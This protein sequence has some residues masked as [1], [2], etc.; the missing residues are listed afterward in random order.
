MRYPG[1]VVWIA[2]LAGVGCK[3][4]ARPVARLSDAAG[5]VEESRQKAQQTWQATAVGHTFFVGDGVRTGA[6]A[7]ARI[8]LEPA[9]TLSLGENSRVR[10]GHEDRRIGLEVGAAEIESG[11]GGVS[12]GTSVGQARIEPSSQVRVRAVDGELRFEVVVGRAI[13]ETDD[14]E[15]EVIAT[16]ETAFVSARGVRHGARKPAHEEPSAAEVDAGPGPL[17][18]GAGEGLPV[19]DFSMAAG[20][21]AVIHAVHPPVAIRFRADGCRGGAAAEL[22]PATRH[23]AREEATA[24]L[25]VPLGRHRYR[26]RCLHGAPHP[27]R[28]RLVVLNDS[29][30]RKLP[31]R[32]PRSH[33]EADGRRYTVLYQNRLPQITFRWP[34]PAAADLKLILQSSAGKTRTFAAPTATYVARSGTVGEGTYTWWFQAVANAGIRSP[35]TR[36]TIR[37]DNTARTAYVG[38]PRVGASWSPA[39]VTVS[40]ATLP[41]YR[42]SAAGQVFATDS[43]RRFSG[44]VAVPAGDGALAIRFF[45]PRR[46]IHYYVRRPARIGRNP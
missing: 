1:A 45:H 10:F 42:V 18:A 17:D 33:L 14:A 6:G 30:Q 3:D 8:A 36:L 22:L 12:V 34:R 44:T 5:S 35:K 9:G 11:P 21:S 4:D 26:V 16:G 24:I 19:A 46:G 20:E 37:L 40:G 7:R 38:E 28:G 43:Q 2:V 31:Q 41:G 29:G 25:S 13:I 39:H 27:V 23:P 32:A 15:P